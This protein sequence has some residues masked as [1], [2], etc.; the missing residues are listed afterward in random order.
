MR[1]NISG[2]ARCTKK[3]IGHFSQ[4]GKDQEINRS[5]T[6]RGLGGTKFFD[7]LFETEGHS[8]GRPVTRRG[9]ELIRRTN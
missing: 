4:A 3:E 7:L 6:G 1:D 8:N 9:K 2:M 5:S